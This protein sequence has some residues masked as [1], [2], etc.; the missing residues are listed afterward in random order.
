MDATRVFATCF[1][2]RCSSNELLSC[3]KAFDLPVAKDL[4]AH[5]LNG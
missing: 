2:P 5:R 1:Y 3:E 4:I